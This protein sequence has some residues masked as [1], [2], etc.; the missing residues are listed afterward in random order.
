MACTYLNNVT[1]CNFSEEQCH[2]VVHKLS[3]SG[4]STHPANCGCC[5]QRSN[6]FEVCYGTVPQKSRTT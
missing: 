4:R 5:S 2:N 6:T 3:I 1:G